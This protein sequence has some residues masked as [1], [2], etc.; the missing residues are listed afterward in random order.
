[1]L[2]GIKINILW[3]GKCRPI[4]LLIN[5]IE[6]R[7]VSVIL[8]GRYLSEFAI[9]YKDLSVFSYVCSYTTLRNAR[10]VICSHYWRWCVIC[11]SKVAVYVFLA[12]FKIFLMHFFL[13][14]TCQLHA[15]VSTNTKYIPHSDAHAAILNPPPLIPVTNPHTGVQSPIHFFFSFSF[16]CLFGLFYVMHGTNVSLSYFFNEFYFKSSSLLVS[17]AL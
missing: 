1:V 7:S 16:L 4:W 17:A 8:A 15:R 9:T 11:H 10:C 12:F 13:Y 6:P 5:F 2:S 3:R 14:T